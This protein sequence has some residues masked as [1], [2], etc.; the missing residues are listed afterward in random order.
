V[1]KLSCYQW[2]ER[3]H[4]ECV[5]EGALV[6]AVQHSFLTKFWLP[7]NTGWSVREEQYIR[8]RMR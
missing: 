1:D 4:G 2:G 5:A 6:L 3:Q 8:R 7:P